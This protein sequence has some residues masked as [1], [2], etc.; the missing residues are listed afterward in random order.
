MAPKHA[1]AASVPRVALAGFYGAGNFGDDLSAVLFGLA[2]GRSGVPFRVYGLCEPYARRFGFETAPSAAP[3][4]DGAG[5]FVWGGG[6]LLVSWSRLTYR[7]LYRSAASQLG[8]I[9][10]EVEARAMPVLLSSV[11]GDGGAVTGLAPAY[12]SRLLSA[13]RWVSVRNPQDVEVLAAA[14]RAAEYYPDVAWGVGAEFPMTRRRG[15]RPRIGID[16]YPSN[17]LRQRAL[18]LVPRLQ[19]LVRARPDWDFVFLDT[20]NASRRPYRGLAGIIRGPNV[21]PYQFRELEADLAAVGSLDAVFSSRFHLPIV[22]MQCG[23]PAVSI[24]AERKTRMLFGNLGLGRF[25]VH[26]E[27][28]GDL[29]EFTGAGL[30]LG[31]L[32]REYPFPDMA[33]LAESSRGHVEG[34]L[35]ALPRTPPGPGAPGDRE[36]YA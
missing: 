19:S 11:G 33:R 23:V 29:A 36:R 27:R 9:V 3:L 10:R 30:D 14:G 7:L 8:A 5:A 16:L 2:L 32:L 12:R 1:A 24:F 6:G 35:R 18:H 20:T 13:A 22:A 21:R 26:H 31:R 34:L 4:L 25:S 28:A 17:L 15:D